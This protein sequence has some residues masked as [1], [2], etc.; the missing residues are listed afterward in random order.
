[1]SNR[2]EKIKIINVQKNEL[3]AST[4]EQVLEM[5]VNSW[6]ESHKKKIELKNIQYSI[7]SDLKASAMLWYSE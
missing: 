4:L 6:L 1:M 2:K 7:S 5:R 3:T